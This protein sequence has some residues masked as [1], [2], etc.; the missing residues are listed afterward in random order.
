MNIYLK[1]IGAVL[2]ITFIS[3]TVSANVSLSKAEADSFARGCY[4][5]VDDITGKHSVFDGSE[6]FGLEPK[7]IYQ[8]TDFLRSDWKYY[9]PKWTTS[10]SY[11][12]H[13]ETTIL[14]GIKREYYGDGWTL[15]DKTELI[16]RS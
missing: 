6:V 2:C 7:A 16:K 14:V 11:G 5:F 9:K 13:F 4:S 15:H 8:I 12:A 1:Q 10:T 3:I